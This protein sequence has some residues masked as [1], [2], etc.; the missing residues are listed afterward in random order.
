MSILFVPRLL[1]PVIAWLG[2]ATA[3]ALADLPAQ[4]I[5]VTVADEVPGAD[6]PPLFL[7]LSMEMSSLLPTNGHYY[8]DPADKAL[9]QTF[10]TLGIKSLRVGANAV[11]KPTVAVPQ[12]KDIDQLFSFARAAGLKVIYSFRLEAGNPADSARLA[13]YIAAHDADALDSF[14]IGNEPNFYLKK[15]ADFFT[16]WQAHYAAILQAVPTAMFE[17]PS[18]AGHE[19]YVLNLAKAVFPG[20]H[21]KMATNH[22]YFL[23]NSRDAEKNP[24]SAREHFLLDSI[25]ERYT[26]DY[27]QVGAVLAQ[28]GVPYRIDEMNSCF[29]GGAKGS[30]DTYAATLWSLD[31]THWWAAHHI[32]GVNYHTIES[33]TANPDGTFNAA[34]YSAFV[35]LPGGEGIDYRPLAYAFAAFTQ[36]AH[37]RPLHVATNV[38]LPFN[39]D[40]YAYKDHDGSLYVTLINKSYGAQAQPASVSLQLPAATK[41]GTWQ[42]LD[43]AQKDND[44]AATTG[45]TLGGAPIDPQGT[46][47]GQWQ[48]IAAD[49]GNPTFQVAPTSAVILR[50]AADK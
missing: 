40:A 6:L 17:G 35:H 29:H 26:R 13:A 24:A 11:D 25:H 7:G 12:E 47:S 30:S 19:E 4:P 38:A 28:E 48:P 45:I 41:S 5:T 8:F 43:L 14:S 49:A 46:W 33:Y 31:C 34:P 1:L 23:G 22:Y 9:V 27:A 32:V 3:S 37:G 50:L 15:Y 16:Q 44:V 18:N 36:G 20:G 2:I 10:R 42:R 39:F 21:L